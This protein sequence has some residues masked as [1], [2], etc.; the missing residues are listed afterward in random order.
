MA[1]LCV[2]VLEGLGVREEAALV[3]LLRVSPV[4]WLVLGGLGVEERV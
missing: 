2:S 4:V 1:N 3:V